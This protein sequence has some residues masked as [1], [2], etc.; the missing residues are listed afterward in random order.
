MNKFHINASEEDVKIIIK[1]IDTDG[2]GTI[3]L[4]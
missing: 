2:N 1:N 3:E 4:P